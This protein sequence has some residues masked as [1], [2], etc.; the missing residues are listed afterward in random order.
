MKKTLLLAAAAAVLLLGATSPN[1]FK[2]PAEMPK[3]FETYVT[4]APDDGVRGPYRLLKPSS[5]FACEAMVTQPGTRKAYGSLELKVPRGETKSV[6][7]NAGEYDLTFK[8]TING[9]AT[10][11][12]A[13]VVVARGADVLSRTRST[14]SLPAKE[15][16]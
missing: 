11:A 14:V 10:R 7:Q 6:H 3:G 13:I 5:A 4:V 12:D 1:I 8:V 16:R 15:E 9:E 2:V